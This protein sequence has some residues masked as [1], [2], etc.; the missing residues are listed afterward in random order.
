MSAKE[1]LK[2]E[3]VS[4]SAREKIIV[5]DINWALDK[6][7]HWVI[8]GPNGAGKSTLLKLIYGFIWPNRSGIV[9]RKGK[10]YIDLGQLRKSIGLVS[11][12]LIRYIN[13]KETVLKTVV[14]GKYGMFG[15]WQ[16][17]DGSLFADDKK[18]ADQIMTK[19]KILKFS[20]RTTRT[21]STGEMQKVL[22]ARA[23]M[24]NPY[25]ILL[26]EPLAGVDPGAQERFLCTLNSYIAE[27]NEPSFI[28]ITHHVSEIIEGFTKMLMMK[29]GKIF[30]NGY[31]DEGL[32]SESISELYGSPFTLRQK[33]NRYHLYANL[34]KG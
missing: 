5:S 30:Y 14:S 20:N 25:L 13:S 31:I 27:H 21:L 16:C 18:K 1:L 12:D 34:V 4:Y 32:S 29:N 11:P 19:L 7:E 6:G 9:Y 17:F 24:S 22:L 23:L 26:D 10:Q 3:N 2:F 8:L 33:N 15:Y 28:Y